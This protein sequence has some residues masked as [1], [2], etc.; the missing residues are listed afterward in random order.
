MR[1][2]F[3]C[4]FLGL[5]FGLPDLL[6]A[7]SPLG[8]SRR[9]PHLVPQ[10][11]NFQAMLLLCPR[12]EA[13]LG[14]LF[15]SLAYSLCT[16]GLTLIMCYTPAALLAARDF[17]G[18]NLLDGLLLTPALVPPMTFAMGLHTVF[19]HLGLA[20]TVMGVVLVLSMFSYP[21]MLRALIAGFQALGP[22]Y[23]LCA[24][25]LGAG[26]WVRL[27]RVELPLLVPAI[28]AGGTVVFL[29]A[30]SEYFLVFLI[31][32]GTVPALTG[33]LFPLLS[34]SD[35]A[36]ASLLTLAFLAVPL[37]LFACVDGVVLSWYRRRGM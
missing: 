7:L 34:S 19:I 36:P 26:V 18:K 1:H 6:L 25:N 2:F 12:H 24:R 23:V 33:T 16:V 13:L 22:D 27:F 17:P 30:F 21:Y 3:F 8:P 28:V 9:F 5:I 20:D 29:V 32:G 15:S 14:D 4:L 31:G 35:R 37:I 11:L 10:H